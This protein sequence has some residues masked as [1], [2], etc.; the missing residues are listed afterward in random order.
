MW[1][2]GVKYTNWVYKEVIQILKDKP[3]T[4]TS[5]YSF[6]KIQLT[7]YMTFKVLLNLPTTQIHRIRLLFGLASKCTLNN[8]RTV[9]ILLC[10]NQYVHKFQHQYTI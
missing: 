10:T 6:K 9:T 5:K 7:L 1:I 2:I 3:H 8:V 4:R